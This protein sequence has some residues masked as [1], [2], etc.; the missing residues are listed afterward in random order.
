MQALKNKLIIIHTIYVQIK[1]V[2][3]LIIRSTFCIYILD[4]LCMLLNGTLAFM[5]INLYVIYNYKPL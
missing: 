5:K 2:L 1:N 4:A 3:I